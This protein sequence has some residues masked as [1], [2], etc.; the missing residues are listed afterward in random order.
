M[1]DASAVP[2]D[3]IGKAKADD[4]ARRE[5]LKQSRDAV[6]EAG[7]LAT[8]LWLSYIFVVLYLA[9]AVSSV[10]HRDLL[11]LN[12]VRMPFLGVELP[13]VAFFWLAPVLFVIAHFYA[14]LHFLLLSEKIETFHNALIDAVPDGAERDLI[15]RR[16]PNNLFMQ[17]MAGPRHI[18]SGP[19]GFSLR[20]IAWT[21]L[22]IA[23]VL[24]LL[25]FQ[26]Q[27]LP[28]HDNPTTQ[29]QRLLI[30]I[31]LVILWC[32]WRPIIERTQRLASS[33]RFRLRLS[34]V[35][36]A[37]V[38][39]LSL[40][41]VTFPGD[42]LDRLRPCRCIPVLTSLAWPVSYELVS[43]HDLLFN[44]PVDLVN[45]KPNSWWSDRLVVPGIDLVDRGKFGRDTRFADI[46]RTYSL[47]G[48]D[49]K[50]AVFNGADLRAV[51]FTGAQLQGASFSGADLRWASFSCE[52]QRASGEGG[53]VRE[54]F[55]AAD[56]RRS[57]DDYTCVNMTAAVLRYARLDNANLAGARLRGAV[58]DGSSMIGADLARAK[59][60]GASLQF[61]DLT[62]ADLSSAHL[63]A[64]RM[65]AAW[66]GAANLNA[67]L[68]WAASMQRAV[69]HG[70][71][72]QF[73]NANFVSLRGAQLQ[74]AD[75]SRTSLEGAF[76]GGTS[77]RRARLPEASAKTPYEFDRVEMNQPIALADY[78]L[79]KQKAEAID[80]RS[81]RQAALARLAIANP[82]QDGAAV[83]PAV[84]PTMLVSERV[85]ATVEF[86]KDL[87]CEFDPRP[88]DARLIEED[89]FHFILGGLLG[90]RGLFG[91]MDSLPSQYK[92]TFARKVLDPEKCKR[93][94]EL[95]EAE[96]RLLG[97]LARD[98]NTRSK[99]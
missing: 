5:V 30:G 82:A 63:V 43:L 62:G 35:A 74:G 21:T 46:R 53:A 45:W 59:L 18:R 65:R 6:V 54:D 91:P 83:D 47:R 48:R 27:F 86:L 51:D 95:G 89:D 15:R 99:D 98:E 2:V 25:L 84:P 36:T 80:A 97:V 42:W 29:F 9:I 56:I 19:I 1:S 79:L 76:M 17:F 49:L 13:L 78:E 55:P 40:T 11:L 37:I 68:L 60:T 33:R 69:L 57:L 12:P 61:V 71:N 81:I 96:K 22:V 73:A 67:A 52:R 66:L 72:L 14:L 8:S 26:V 23:P 31:D 38:A 39:L 41:L 44:G 16:L 58:L 77:L 20:L 75:L 90:Q 7:A 4:A 50:G 70:A 93:S 64:A 10:S 28:Y 34:A 94:N 24:L 88:S 3:Q 87:V 92:G 85:A 32:L